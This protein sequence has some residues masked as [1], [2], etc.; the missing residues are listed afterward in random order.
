MKET[1]CAMVF[2][3]QPVSFIFSGYQTLSQEFSVIIKII[4]QTLIAELFGNV[5]IELPVGFVA[6]FDGGKHVF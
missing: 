2:V 3:A 5:L 6:I 4:F 1:G